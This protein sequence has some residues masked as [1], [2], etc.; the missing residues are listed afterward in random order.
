MRK[1]PL[2]L[3][4]HTSS[5]V[6]AVFVL[7]QT[8]CSPNIKTKPKKT[9]QKSCCF[10]FNSEKPLLT[11]H[12]PQNCRSKCGSVLH[13]HVW[14][15]VR[16]KFF[17]IDITASVRKARNLSEGIKEVDAVQLALSLKV[18]LKVLCFEKKVKHGEMEL[19]RI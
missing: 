11:H 14:D 13:S 10:G 1:Q 9:P 19:L 6:R 5:S 3:T 15:S 18:S 7:H 2:Q 16:R 4:T 17:F 8:E 12:R